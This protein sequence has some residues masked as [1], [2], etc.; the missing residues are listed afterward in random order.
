[1]DYETL[2]AKWSE[3]FGEKNMPSTR[4]IIKQLRERFE[5][6]Q[7][8]KAH[9]VL[10]LTGLSLLPEETGTEGTQNLFLT[11]S[12]KI[13]KGIGEMEN[14]TFGTLGTRKGESESRLPEGSTED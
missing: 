6:L 3:F 10:Y 14:D 8:V 12:R 11:P 4:N 13:E 5:F 2:L 7:T 9:S 1:M